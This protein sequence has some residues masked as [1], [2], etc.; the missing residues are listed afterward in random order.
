MFFLFLG[1]LVGLFPH[2]SH[3]HTIST[4]VRRF[5]LRPDEDDEDDEVRHPRL[6]QEEAEVKD[7]EDAT[8][9]AKDQRSFGRSL[10]PFERSQVRGQPGKELLWQMGM[11]P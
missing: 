5:H 9:K 1:G 8:L 6:A 11:Y 3:T 10:Q 7:A 4:P 2:E